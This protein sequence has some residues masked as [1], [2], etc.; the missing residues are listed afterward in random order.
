MYFILINVTLY[1]DW[2]GN[3]NGRGGGMQARA[4]KLGTVR[5]ESVPPAYDKGC[6]RMKIDDD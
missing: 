3:G 1:T 2:N 5:V 4:R 6:V